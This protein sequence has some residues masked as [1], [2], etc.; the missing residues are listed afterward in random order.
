VHWHPALSRTLADLEIRLC[1]AAFD[2]RSRPWARR[3]HLDEA[4]V[5]TMGPTHRLAT[6][7][8]HV[9]YPKL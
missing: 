7:H 9:P 1:S 2:R 4:L 8:L 3:T 5:L 6:L